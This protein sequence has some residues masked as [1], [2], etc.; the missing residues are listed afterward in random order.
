MLALVQVPFNININ[1]A[2]QTSVTFVSFENICY[3]KSNGTLRNSSSI[4]Y[5]VSYKLINFTFDHN[6]FHF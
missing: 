2:N 3:V 1:L 6:H 4:K 5:I